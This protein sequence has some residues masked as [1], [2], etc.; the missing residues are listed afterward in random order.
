MKH[1]MGRVLSLLLVFFMVLTVGALPAQALESVFAPS[2]SYANSEYYQR[3]LDVELTGDARTD[4]INIALSQMGYREGGM[5][6]EYGGS[7]RLC[8]NYTEYGY[9]YGDP[10]CIWCTTFIWWCARQAGLDE[11]V[12]PNTVWPRLLAVNC[13]YVGYTTNALVQPGDILFVENSGDSTTDHL[14]LVLEV[15]DTQIIA[16]EGNCGN[17]VAKIAYER[18]IGGRADGMGDILYIGYPNYTRDPSIPAASALTQYA[19]LVNDTDLYNKHSGGSNQG[20]TQAGQL[21]QLLAV[22]NDSL[23]YQIELGD[24]AYWIPAENAI[25][26]SMDEIYEQLSALETTTT[27]TITTVPDVTTTEPTVTDGGTEVTTSLQDG[28]NPLEQTA[29]ASTTT[30]PVYTVHVM[31][32][33]EA[34]AYEQEDGEQSW[35]DAIGGMETL[36]LA[37]MFVLVIIVFVMLMLIISRRK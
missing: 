2:E 10:D 21:L 3:L 7:G 4:V 33:D 6:G 8:N 32:Y 29:A 25:I 20:R 22:R 31:P 34:A 19:Y 30:Q 37:G 16:I 26:G 36:V 12:F 5:A 28:V 18:N 17:A 15:T 1:R 13:P 11:T 23:W 24:Y 9:N 27:T 35:L 14:A